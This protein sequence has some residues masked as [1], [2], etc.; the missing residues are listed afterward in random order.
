MRSS[1]IPHAFSEEPSARPF[2][3]RRRSIGAA[4]AA[5]RDIAGQHRH[6]SANRSSTSI[7]FYTGGDPPAAAK[8]RKRFLFTGVAACCRLVM[9]I[10][11]R[12]CIRSPGSAGSKAD[13]VRRSPCTYAIQRHHHHY[14]L[15]Y[16]LR[17]DNLQQSIIFTTHAIAS[18][19]AP[20]SSVPSSSPRN[21]QRSRVRLAQNDFSSMDG[22]KAQTE[23]E[24]RATH[25]RATQSKTRSRLT[26]F[27]AATASS[28]GRCAPAVAKGAK[29][30]KE[31]MAEYHQIS[32]DATGETAAACRVM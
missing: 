4:L 18:S 17:I 11:H 30:R 22:T 9:R 14:T 2:G 16:R 29:A 27:S 20:E 10:C 32:P 31:M 1:S 15:S 3:H 13:Y 12:P 7:P 25:Q 19:P 28:R 24:R 6:R 26:T 8:R 21:H 5:R 23:R